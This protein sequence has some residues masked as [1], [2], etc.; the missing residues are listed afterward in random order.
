MFGLFAIFFPLSFS[1]RWAFL[2]LLFIRF[3]C[4]VSCWLC[5]L[6][7]IHFMNSICEIMYTDQ[8]HTLQTA[9][10]SNAI[11]IGCSRTR[12]TKKVLRFFRA[13][14]PFSNSDKS[15][16]VMGEYMDW[17]PQS[18]SIESPGK[19]NFTEIYKF[20]L[21]GKRMAI[22]QRELWESEAF[23]SHFAKLIYRCECMSPAS[24]EHW[25]EA[26]RKK[27]VEHPI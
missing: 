14:F 17:A 24:T 10:R 8:A 19:I 20:R 1:L 16:W 4:I 5:K 7:C 11:A 6:K 15:S 22:N 26:D 3:A 27:C 2:L 21:I 13:Q 25:H 18:W 12:N 9:V 23:F